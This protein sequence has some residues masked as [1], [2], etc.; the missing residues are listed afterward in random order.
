M[1][2]DLR[3]LRFFV[4]V[5]ERLSFTR[6]AEDL[7]VAQPSLSKQIRQLERNLRVQLFNRTSHHVKLT[8]AGELLL[9][10][11]RELLDAWATTVTSIR[12]VAAAESHVLRVGFVASA[13]NELTPSI[14]R[15]FAEHRPGWRVEMS[16]TDWQDPTA[17]LASG[18]VDVALLRLPVPLDAT[19]SSQ[20]LLEEPR[21]VALSV[22]H[23]LAGHEVI[24]LDQLLDEPFVAPPEESGA[25]RAYCLAAD[26]RGGHP[27]RIGAVV[28]RPD[29]WLIAIAN[30][31]GVAFTPLA[32]ARYYQRPDIAY[33]PVEGIS[34]SQ[35]A[36]VWPRETTAATTLE[37]VRVCLETA[38]A[39]RGRSPGA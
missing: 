4:A 15:L 19:F 31:L 18:A 29:E 17:G 3:H 10:E 8:G 32:T 12:E 6:A 11:A 1:D 39:A 34:G 25:W 26:E 21:C 5:A 24:R 27:I 16:Q 30:N 2:A 37:F 33:R 20:V 9:R 14:L 36:V 13:A 38:H 22:S 23:P 7:H 28:K 35:V